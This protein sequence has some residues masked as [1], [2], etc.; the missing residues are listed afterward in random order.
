MN[1]SYNFRPSRIAITG[2]TGFIGSAIAKRLLM[3]GVPEVIVLSRRGQLPPWLED[4]RPN[5][6]LKAV[7]CDIRN[8][9][10]VLKALT[11]CDAVFHQAALRV[12]RCAQEPHLAYEIIVCG[13]SNVLAA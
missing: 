12:T 10:S 3:E 1:E 13:T 2:G 7:V 5:G 6:R 8:R 9:D 4:W 11:G